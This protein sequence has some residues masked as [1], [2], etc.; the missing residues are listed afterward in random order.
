[1]LNKIVV[2]E[3]SMPQRSEVHLFIY[4]WLAFDYSTQEQIHSHANFI[5]N[6]STW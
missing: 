6:H 2:G 3:V 1:M 5:H 4:G